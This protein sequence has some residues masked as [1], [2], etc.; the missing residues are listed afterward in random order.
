MLNKSLI[1]LSTMAFCLTSLSI[2]LSEA[3]QG[4]IA[5]WNVQAWSAIDQCRRSLATC[6]VAQIM[7]ESSP[8]E[9]ALGSLGMLFIGIFASGIFGC[10][11]VMSIAAFLGG[12]LLAFDNSTLATKDAELIVL[13]GA[14]AAVSLTG[15]FVGMKGWLLSLAIFAV[16]ILLIPLSLIEFI[17][18]RIAEHEK[19]PL[20]A[21]GVLVAAA[22]SLLK[23]IL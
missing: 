18:R 19:G 10:F 5:T 14:M 11:S 21:V 16:A 2:F 9:T 22:L 12:I 1:L 20:V 3:Q 23:A 7:Q 13:W 17:S 6:R 4:S 15:L 8:F